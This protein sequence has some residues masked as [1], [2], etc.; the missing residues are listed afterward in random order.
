M[1]E[2]FAW[3]IMVQHHMLL[4]L[5]DTMKWFFMWHAHDPFSRLDSNGFAT[6]LLLRSMDLN[7]QTNHETEPLIWIY[8]YIYII[9]WTHGPPP[10]VVTSD[11]YVCQVYM[12]SNWLDT[13][14]ECDQSFCLIYIFINKFSK[15][16][17]G[18]S[19]R[20]TI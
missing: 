6:N 18:L 2:Y 16:I 8:I 7:S 1:M 4:N 5:F 19:S 14:P 13:E 20:S 15:R 10:L 3:I 9:Y 12:W 11:P 17:S